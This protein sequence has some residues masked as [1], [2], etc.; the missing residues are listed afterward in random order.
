M[1][2]PLQNARH[3]VWVSR[4]SSE[5]T[6]INGCPVS[7]KVWN[8]KEPSLLMAMSA[9][10]RSKF[11]PLHRQTWR[12]HMSEKFSSGTINS[13]KN[14]NKQTIK[15][16]SFFVQGTI[17]MRYMYTGTWQ[18]SIFSSCYIT[19][20][21]HNRKGKQMKRINNKSIMLSSKQK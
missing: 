3:L 1:T 17:F 8:A 6:I 11:A 16:M 13:K 18:F 12:L 2:A 7:Q 20:S 9:E 19:L 15:K 10:H 14:P 21:L 5:M 4:G